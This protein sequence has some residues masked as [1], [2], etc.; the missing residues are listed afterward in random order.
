MDLEDLLDL[1]L[2]GGRNEK[3][4]RVRAEDGDDEKM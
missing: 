1:Y 4:E 3:R 2:F